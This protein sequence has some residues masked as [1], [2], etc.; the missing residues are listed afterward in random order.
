MRTTAA[1][2][3]DETIPRRWP[4]SWWNR[5]TCRVA[6]VVCAACMALPIA[7]Q[8]AATPF[9]PAASAV[10]APTCVHTVRWSSNLAKVQR[11]ADGISP[12]QDSDIAQEVLRRLG[13]KA[14]FIDLPWARALVE[15]ELFESFFRASNAAEVSGTGLGLAI[16]KRSVELHGGTITVSSVLSQGSIFVVLLP[17]QN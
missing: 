6:V 2:K 9:V 10:A 14:K 4:Q 11:N 17:I 3:I 15:L 5:S 7:S 13:C 1:M 12:S 8:T 16:V